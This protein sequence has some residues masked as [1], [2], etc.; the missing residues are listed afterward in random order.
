MRKAI[1]AIAAVFLPLVASAQTTS[2]I[3]SISDVQRT[4]NNWVGYLFNIFWVIAVGMLIWAAILYL[5][6]GENEDNVTK[7]K[8][9]I[10][11]AVIAAVIALLANGLYPI[12]SSILQ[13]K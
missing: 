12:V 10:M 3:T 13:T 11:Y 5:T 1:S 6:G 2:P 8:K 4:L 9:I 7:A